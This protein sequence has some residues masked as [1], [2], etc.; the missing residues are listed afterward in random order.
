MIKHQ[1]SGG[2]D[3]SRRIRNVH[4]SDSRFNL[5]PIHFMTTLVRSVIRLNGNFLNVDKNFPHKIEVSLSLLFALHAQS[6]VIWDTESFRRQEKIFHH[7]TNFNAGKEFYRTEQLFRLDQLI[8]HSNY[9][10]ICLSIFETCLLFES[11][12]LSSSASSQLKSFPTFIYI[13]AAAFMSNESRNCF[14]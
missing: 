2:G 6:R 11:E 13:F 5:F 1:K 10:E 4:P 12:L 9:E 3:L 8:S 7:A 14:S